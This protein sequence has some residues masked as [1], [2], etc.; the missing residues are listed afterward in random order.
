M[1]KSKYIIFF[2]TIFLASCVSSPPED[3]DNLCRIFM[4]KR[5]WYKAAIQTEK[6]W[7]LPPF[8]LIAFVFQESSF[9]SNAKPDREKLFGIIPWLRPSTAKGYSQALDETWEQYIDE[10]GNTW[11]RRGS[12]SDS[13]D[14]IGW[15]AEK[16]IDSGIKKTDARSLYLAYHDGYTGFKN[17]TYR[18]KQWLMDVADRVQNRSNM[19][20]RQYWGCAEDLRKESKRL[21][22]F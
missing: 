2:T 13:A 11:A 22:F 8:V 16:G 4:E 5:S 3:P 17:R 1:K 7:E 15:Y 18:Q 21:F 10:T 14:F 20:Q 9:N 19:Y 6:K 12:F